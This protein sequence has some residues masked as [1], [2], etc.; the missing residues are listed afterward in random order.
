MGLVFV[1][2]R[3]AT[4]LLKNMTYDLK[5]LTKPYLTTSLMENLYKYNYKYF[6]QGFDKSS[7]YRAAISLTTLS[8]G[9]IWYLVYLLGKRENRWVPGTGGIQNPANPNARACRHMHGPDIQG[10]YLCPVFSRK[11]LSRKGVEE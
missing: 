5:S 3:I 8:Q 2:V 6:H 11:E 1:F 10:R 7:S 4:A 9:F